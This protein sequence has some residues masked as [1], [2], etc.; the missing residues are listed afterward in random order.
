M[1]Q[2]NYNAIGT[3]S[4]PATL[5][6]A[7]T[8]NAYEQIS[9]YMPNM[10]INYVY[11]PKALETDRLCYLLVEIS[12]DGGTTWLPWNNTTNSTT[13]TKI[14]PEGDVSTDGIPFVIPGDGTSTGGTA[15]SGTFNIEVRGE[16]IRISARESG[17]ADFGTL[18]T[19]I[20]LSS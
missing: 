13:S 16:M 12:N 2:V 14:Y 7:Y 19:N 5:T 15:L 6:A 17:G 20:S 1:E 18:F 3:P 8:G 4:A 9:K 10:T 11:T